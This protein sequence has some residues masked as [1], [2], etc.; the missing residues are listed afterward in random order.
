[1]YRSDQRGW[2]EGVGGA[3]L[4]TRVNTLSMTGLWIALMEG[5]AGI[6]YNPTNSFHVEI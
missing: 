1:M 2:M 6:R 5:R 3:Y 4:N